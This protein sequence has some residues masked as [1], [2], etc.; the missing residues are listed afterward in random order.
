MPGSKIRLI[1]SYHKYISITLISNSINKMW[2]T[3]T[4]KLGD[5]GLGLMLSVAVS[6]SHYGI[7]G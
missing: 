2:T 5:F 6:S 7:S 1:T 4:T 3:N